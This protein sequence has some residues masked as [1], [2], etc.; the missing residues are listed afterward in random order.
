M[1]ILD[2]KIK[3]RLKVN[4]GVF[5]FMPKMTCVP[6]ILFLGTAQ[7][8]FRTRKTISLT[9]LVGSPLRIVQSQARTPVSPAL[10]WWS[11][12]ARL[13]LVPLPNCWTRPVT[14]WP[15]ESFKVSFA[16]VTGGPWLSVVGDPFVPLPVELLSVC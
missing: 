5:S 14:A 11:G 16:S 10:Q 7:L 15:W 6:R 2:E 13:P 3:G 4:V 8:C 1:N 12:T 9:C